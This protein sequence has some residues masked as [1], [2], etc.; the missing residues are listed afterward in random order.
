MQCVNPV[1]ITKGLEIKYPDGL[2]VPCGKC[3]ACR[4]AKRKEWSLRL[5]H[6]L[7]AWD[8]SIFITL[9]YTDQHLPDHSSLK[10]YH[11]QLFWKRLRK[12]L[13]PHRKIKYFA[14]GEYGD[15]TQRPHYHAIVYG[16][17]LNSYDRQLVMDAWPYSD[18]TNSHIKQNSFGAAEADSINYVAQYIDKKFSGDKADEEYRH[19]NREPVFRLLS[20]GLG[21]NYCIDN[22]DQLKADLSVRYRGTDHALPRY[23]I[24]KLN[25]SGSEELLKRALCA[26]NEVVEHYTGL[27]VNADDL[28]RSGSVSDNAKLIKGLK[29]AREQH[30]RN[31]EA[32]IN[33]KQKK[34]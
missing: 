34:L 8:D 26:N 1:R 12:L 32:R 30:K 4:I 10:K 28:Y 15:I 7:E 6:E 19:K 17:S 3:V 11:L 23:Y 24:K 13:P 29:G 20:L 31:L 21:L 9:T 22:S 14:C 33:L 25:L 2:M 16:L 18:W 27:Y 5:L